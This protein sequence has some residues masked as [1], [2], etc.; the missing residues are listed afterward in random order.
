MR[1]IVIIAVIAISVFVLSWSYFKFFSRSQNTELPENFIE[2]ILFYELTPFIVEKTRDK[3]PQMEI[4]SAM[5]IQGFMF[6]AQWKTEDEIAQEA[7]P[8]AYDFVWCSELVP[9]F[10]LQYANEYFYGSDCLIL[11]ERRLWER[12]KIILKKPKG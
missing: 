9:E 1:I 4:A 5:E 7:R 8:W 10:E 12:P 2:H 3:D 11:R 6:S